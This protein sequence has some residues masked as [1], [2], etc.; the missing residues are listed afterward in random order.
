[1]RKHPYK[2]GVRK[3]VNFVAKNVC[4]K[5]WNKSKI[6]SLNILLH[7]TAV[8]SFCSVTLKYGIALHVNI[9]CNNSVTIKLSFLLLWLYTGLY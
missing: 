8:K 5:F 1:M 3:P 2:H 4:G 9:S 7:A 6:A